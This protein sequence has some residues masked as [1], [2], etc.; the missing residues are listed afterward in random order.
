MGVAREKD[1]KINTRLATHVYA[2]NLITNKDR[3]LGA[4]SIDAEFDWKPSGAVN[5]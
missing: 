4:V 5:C 1:V 2:V 3:L